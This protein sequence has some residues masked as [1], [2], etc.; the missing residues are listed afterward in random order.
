MHNLSVSLSV[1]VSVCLPPSIP[2]LPLS[3]GDSSA[4]HSLHTSSSSNIGLSL[5]LKAA[6]TSSL[7]PHT[8]KLKAS[9]TNS[10][11]SASSCLA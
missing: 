4:C 8:V 3:V 11:N 2:L 1:S 9:Y 10:F 7:R 5:W 6:Y